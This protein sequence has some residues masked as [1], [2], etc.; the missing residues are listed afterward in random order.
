LQKKGIYG[1]VQKKSGVEKFT[2]SKSSIFKTLPFGKRTDHSLGKVPF[3]LDS[4]FLANGI[5]NPPSIFS[6]TPE[7][8]LSID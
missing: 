5:D 1:Q 4:V 3:F 7:V 6:I 8:L 2:F